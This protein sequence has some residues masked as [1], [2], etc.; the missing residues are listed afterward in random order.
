MRKGFS[1][2]LALCMALLLSVPAFA[3]GRGPAFTSYDVVCTKDTPYYRE[4]WERDGVM[5][6]EGTFPAGTTL[7][8]EYEYE[9]DGVL[10][11]DVQVGEGEDMEWMYI[12][13]SDVE[14]KNDIYLPENAQKLSRA[15]TVR[16]IAR[17][18]ISMY[19]GPNTR[20]E[21]LST[22]P[23]GTKL[24]YSY[25]NDEDD[26]YRTWAYVNFLGKSGWIYVYAPDTQNGVAEL[27]AED[28]K[29][30][31][32]VLEDGVQLYSGLSFGNMENELDSDWGEDV[33]A[34]RHEEPDRVLGTLDKGKTYTYRYSH[35]QDYGTWYYVAS[36]LR[37]GW[38]F[39]SDDNSRIAA[40]ATGEDRE[41]YMTYKTFDL[42]L[43]EAPRK[44]ADGASVRIPKNTVLQADYV[45]HRDYEPF[46]YMTVQGQSGWF[47]SEEAGKA[48]AYKTYNTYEG[49]L[50][51]NR[52]NQPA[53]IYSD[54]TAQD[55]TVG[56]I[57][58]GG[59]FTPLYY[60]DYE[61][62]I[63]EENSEWTFFYYVR[64][65]DVT[66]WVI[67]KDLW[68]PDDEQYED[69]PEEETEDYTEWAEDETPEETEWVE[70]AAEEEDDVYTGAPVP[71]S[72][73]SPLQI[74]LVCVGAAVVLAL[75]AAV[76]LALIRRKRSS[77]ADAQAAAPEAAPAEA[78]PADETDE[79]S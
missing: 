24:T 36:G 1:F 63:D 45:A 77:K 16:V 19:T 75:T 39:M 15:H 26:Y 8:V 11:G 41:R 54:I 57:P 22:I 76:T 48:C 12:L 28:V 60:G 17:E 23:R 78:E 35:K 6:K 73:L 33:I 59:R 62:Q 27:P 4:D 47:S 70:D 72:S 44:N 5:E 49:Y 74:V 55:K 21:K 71:Q 42:K 69:E 10:Y 67:E 32:W 31:I 79:P 53:A 14:M 61:T 37:A 9:K 64:C 56:S 34:E 38:V 3:D 13:L 7:T 18:G 68:N 40:A 66:G 30:E 43:H 52:N 25:G 65:N 46:Y 58:A 2:I 50:E 51:K 20:Y 29:A